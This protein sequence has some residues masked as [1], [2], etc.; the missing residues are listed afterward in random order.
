M[1]RF[2]SIL[3]ILDQS[4]RDEATLAPA[5]TLARENRAH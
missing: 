4:D 1:K 2:K 3:L 5:A